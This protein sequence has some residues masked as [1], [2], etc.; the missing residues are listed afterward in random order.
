M[1]LFVKDVIDRFSQGLTLDGEK[2]IFEDGKELSSD[3]LKER[4]KPESYTIELIIRKIFDKLEVDILPE[5]QIEVLDLELNEKLRNV[6]FRIK[7][8]NLKILV[9]AK[10]VNSDLK[11]D[12]SSGAVNQIKG[13]FKM[14]EVSNNYDFGIATDGLKWIFIDN[15]GKKTEEI[16]IRDSFDRLKE[17][18]LGKEKVISRETE[19]EIS[20]KFYDWYNALLHGGKYKNH[21]NITKN[22][23]KKYCLVENILSAPIVE[24]REQIA[25]TIMDRLIFIKFLQ[26]KGIINFDVLNYLSNLEEKSLN[27]TLRQLFFNVLNTEK[28]KRE[29]I[30]HK[31]N[32]IPYLNGSLFV[33]TEEELK[34]PD[35][36]IRAY[37]LKEIITFLDSFKFIHV[38]RLSNQ[39][40]LDPEILGY[41]FEQAMTASDRH[42]TGAY[43]TSKEI[44]NY[45]SQ[46]TIYPIIVKRANEYLRKIG[47]KEGELIKTID[48]LFDKINPPSIKNIMTEVVYNLKVCDNSCG[49][50]AFL[51]AVGEILFNL[52]KRAKEI[53][54]LPMPDYWFKKEIIKNCIY[55][56]DKNPNAIEIAKLRLWL[57]I[58]DSYSPEKF[59]P[60][61][62][63]EYNVRC[64]NSLIGYISIEKFEQNKTD[65]NDYGDTLTERSLYKT[66]ARRAD[67]IRRYKSLS[68]DGAKLLKSE[69]NRIDDGIKRLL[70]N[71]L[72][73][74]IQKEIKNVKFEDIRRLRAF[75]WGF[76]FGNVFKDNNSERGFDAMVGNPPY[77][78]SR[79]PQFT[80]EMKDM[81]QYSVK[82]EFPEENN[83]IGRGCDLLV[84]FYIRGLSI[85]K[86]DG[87][88]SFITQNSWLD[89]DYGKMFQ[90]FISN[91]TNVKA[92]VDSDFKYFSN[93][94]IN[95]V[96][97]FFV[98]N[99]K[100]VDSKNKTLFLNYHIRFGEINYMLPVISDDMEQPKKISIKIFD[101]SELKNTEFKWG[102]LLFSD[103]RFLEILSI[104]NKKGKKLDDL[105]YGCGQGLN[106]TKDHLIDMNKMKELGINSKSMVP[107][108]SSEDG[109]PYNLSKTQFYLINKDKLSSDKLQQIKNQSIK[110][111]DKIY[112]TR[113]RPNLILPRG[114]GRHFC[115]MNEVN[116]FTTS[117]VEIYVKSNDYDKSVRLWTFLNSSLLWLLREI[118]GRKNL[119]G[120]MLK[121]EAT[122]LKNFELY[123]DLDVKKCKE[124]YS[125]TMGKEAEPALL[126]IGT[127]AH[128]M[129]DKM[130]FDYLGLNNNQRS[131][132]IEKLKDV[133]TRRER[134][135]SKV[136]V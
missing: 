67:L 56:V 69:L 98:G 96:V 41:I 89:T 111:L 52:W 116:A 131:Y 65:L 87:F 88:I 40:T 73:L 7:S 36:R 15:S 17:L 133:V 66:L 29:E 129:I 113:L 38:E 8:K 3:F 92:I 109:A 13:L 61:P 101:Q 31:L 49:S 57:W 136:S 47:Y 53:V 1:D 11:T 110:I 50:G 85:I 46:N 95:T 117:M 134:R 82:K 94:N 123:F 107:I 60:L 83:L 105:G 90:R 106:I 127:T 78:E 27:D 9:E 70:D 84:Y 114:I 126:E 108:M 72:F 48:D 14:T 86:S 75:H 80:D 63:I 119:G 102:L 30:D 112:S 44:T 79:S 43:Y 130:V 20:K 99:K 10:P 28:G 6:D 18:I 55:G 132:V 76:E 22:I 100:C 81:I 118:S 42:G 5:K 51:L 33:R 122:D 35:Y 37:I 125:M 45:I 58:V 115:C 54:N 91:N 12:S 26:S 62:N 120:G 64:G 34:N 135:S 71:K 2:R 124:I 74:E 19:E 97:T 104:M 24:E 25:Q 68:G 16:D 93:A 121:A 4:A 103:N 59:E 39:K 21:L 32:N 128:K 23:S 77:L